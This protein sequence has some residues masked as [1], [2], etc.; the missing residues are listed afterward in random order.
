VTVEAAPD[1]ALEQVR[2]RPRHHEVVRLA[3]TLEPRA[4]RFLER[5]FELQVLGRLVVFIPQSR[6]CRLL[7]KHGVS[8]IAHYEVKNK[9]TCEALLRFL[10]ASSLAIFL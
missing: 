5:A 4:L 8:L 2:L 6:L 9:L 1:D 10:L 7:K 3:N